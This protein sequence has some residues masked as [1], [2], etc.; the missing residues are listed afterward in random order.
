[1]K[2]F[3]S[4]D[5]LDHTGP[6]VSESKIAYSIVGWCARIREDPN[7]ASICALI[8]ALVPGKSQHPELKLG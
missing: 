7:C 3:M 2:R 4:R 1:M 8:A 6:E 5:V